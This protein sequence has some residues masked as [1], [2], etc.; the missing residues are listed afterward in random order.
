MKACKAHYKAPPLAGELS[1]NDSE[2]TEGEHLAA[3]ARSELFPFRHGYA[4]PLSP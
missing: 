4:M 2:Q 1:V 3:L